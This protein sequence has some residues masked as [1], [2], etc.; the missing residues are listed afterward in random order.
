MANHK[1]DY[2]PTTSQSQVVRGVMSAGPPPLPGPPPLRVSIPKPSKKTS[3]VAWVVFFILALVAFVVDTAMTICIFALQNPRIPYPTL[4]A[5]AAILSSVLLPAAIVMGI[6]ALWKG[7]RR[8]FTQLVW[9]FGM[10]VMLA[11]PKL[12]HFAFVLFAQP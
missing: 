3:R 5:V 10:M 7:N 1:M 12:L 6:A 11:P 9:F 4:N 8:A 2:L